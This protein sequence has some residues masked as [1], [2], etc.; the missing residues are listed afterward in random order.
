MGLT[1]VCCTRKDSWWSLKQR[2]KYISKQKK[3][4]RMFGSKS[5]NGENHKMEA[6][7]VS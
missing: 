1:T 6:T 7:T 3:L 5:W 2:K 4:R